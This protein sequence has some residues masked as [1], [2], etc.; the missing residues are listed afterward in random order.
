[1]FRL[2]PSLPPQLSSSL[3]LSKKTPKFLLLLNELNI[4]FVNHI[5]YLP[6]IFDKRFTGRLHV[7]VIKA[8]SFR[9]FI[10]IHSLFKSERLSAIIKFILHKAHV[11]SVMTYAWPAWEFAADTHLMKLR[12]PR[13]KR[14]RTIGKFPRP[15]S[16]CGLHMAYQL[17]CVYDYIA[18]LSRHQAEIIQDILY[19]SFLLHS[20]NT[21]YLFFCPSM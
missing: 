3:S 8:N 18:K 16:I 11:R 7:E 2:H 19:F 13:N 20:F 1:M 12:R 10:R 9:T 5:K 17:P 15:T 14:H 4:Q 21:E 6:V